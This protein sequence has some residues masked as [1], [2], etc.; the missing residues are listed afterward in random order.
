VQF[1]EQR[2]GDKPDPVDFTTITMPENQQAATAT[3]QDRAARIRALPKQ[4][5]VPVPMRPLLPQEAKQ[6]G[7]ILDAGSPAQVTDLFNDLRDAAGSSDVFR[8]MIQQVAPDRPV[9]AAAAVLA[10]TQRDLT[11]NSHWF[12]PDE[13]ITSRNVAGT[14]LIG[15]RLL[16]R[17]GTVKSEDGKPQNQLYLTE[18]ASKGL[19]DQFGKIVGTAFRNDPIGA[20]RAL[21][22]VRAYYVGKA[23]T[24]GTLARDGQTVDYEARARSCAVDARQRGRLS[25]QRRCARALG[26][27]RRR[28]R[29]PRGARAARHARAGGPLPGPRAGRLLR[30]RRWADRRHLRD[31]GR[32]QAPARC[33]QPPVILDIRPSDPRDRRGFIDRGGQ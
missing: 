11:T 21:Q 3:L 30:P 10:S 5:G 15:D 19:Q 17:S 32:P 13:S 29:G 14:M 18:A 20:E 27:E 2:L 24:V 6:L 16:N 31:H 28:L 4:F 1:G 25:R 33:E 22:N 7:G 9:T 23:A 12:S 26:H 8:G